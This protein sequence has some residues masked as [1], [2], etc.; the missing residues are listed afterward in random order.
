MNFILSTKY[1]SLY[2]CTGRNGIY[3]LQGWGNRKKKYLR[4]VWIDV[5]WLDSKLFTNR[6]GEL[7]LSSTI[8]TT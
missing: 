4:N 7:T 5:K 6:N 3:D 1:T 8:S 2:T